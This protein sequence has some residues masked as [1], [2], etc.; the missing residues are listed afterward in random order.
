MGQWYFNPIGDSWLLVGAALV[1]LGAAFVFGG[2]ASRAKLRQRR[3]LIAL[4]I[5]VFLLVLIAMVR[6]THVFTD[7]KKQTS[8]LVVLVDRS[9]SM[10]VPDMFGSS[11]QTRWDALGETLQDA[12]P[13]LQEME[14]ADEFEVKVYA[15]DSQITPIGLSDG[16][17][18]LGSASGSQTAIGATLEDVLRREAGKRLAGV[19]LLSDGAHQAYAPRD[20]PP[21]TAVRRLADLGYPL[22]TFVYGQALT[23]GQARDAAL[24]DLNV[25]STVFVKNEL[26]IDAAAM[27]R[28]LVNM[29]VPVQVLLEAEKGKMEVVDTKNLTANQDGQELPVEMSIVPQV[30]GEHK[31]TLRI[32]PQERELVTSNNELSTF[33]TVL[34]GGLNVLYLEGDPRFEQ[35]ILRRSLGLSPDIKVD[36]QSHDHLS[37]AQWPLDFSEEFA[38]GKYDVYVLGDLDSSVFKPED[39]ELLKSTVRGGA[40][41]IMLGG[42]HSFW[43]GG[44]QNTPLA[45]VLPIKPDQFQGNV[46]QEFDTPI[47]KDLHTDAETRMVP[48]RRFGDISIMMLA[49]VPKNRDA[50]LKLP[51]L[52]G[53]NRFF[54]QNLK[55]TAKVIGE[56]E[57]GEPLLVADDYGSGRVLAFAGDS[58]WHWWMQGFQAEH[59]RFWRQVVLWLAHK[60]ESAEGSVWVKLA[61]RRFTPGRRVEITAGAQSALGEPIPDAQYQAEVIMPDGKRRPLRLSRQGEE[62]AGSFLE[63]TTTGDYTVAVT[64]TRNGENLGTA[65]ARFL[66]YEQDLEMDNAAARPALLTHL[67]KM[68]EAFGGRALAAEQLPSLLDELKNKPPEL[69]VLT[70]TKQTPWDSPPFFLLIVGLLTAEWY[71]RKKWG[72]V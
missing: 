8:T 45:E 9:R 48:G 28:G 72:L 58:T 19:V 12:L 15:F 35:V 33:I 60:D 37:S 51:P 41:L 25:S 68:T 5:A 18:E 70:E 42:F 23:V 3:S 7:A 36:R 32:P 63:T 59:K 1:V 65:Q 34:K 10:L 55:P 47:R 24:K 56:N 71:L 64:A 67:A 40:G 14:A 31:L 22:Y 11:Q 57:K 13:T 39:L 52:E 61:Q 46:R 21:E 50:W 16:S 4:R 26:P 38:P 54:Q 29:D 44:Y 17:L 30:A 69:E 62:T 2:T 66:V 53:A 6:P 20:L 43:G 27:L 49:P